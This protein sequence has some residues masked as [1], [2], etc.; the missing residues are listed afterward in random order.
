MLRAPFL[1]SLLAIGATLAAQ[2]PTK[3]PPWWNVQDDVTVS[4]SY[5]FSGPTP[6]Q[7]TTAVVPSWYS[8]TVTAFTVPPAVTLIPQLNGHTDVLGIVG[9]GAPRS[10]LLKL[11]VDN[12]PHLDWVKIFWFQFDSFEGASGSIRKAIEQDLGQYK[13]T[14]VSET[15]V[16]LGS[17]W[18]QVTIEAQLIPQPGDETVDWT[19]TETALGAVAIDN[20]FVSS[21]CVKPGPDETGDAMGQIEGFAIDLTN[22]T[23]ADCR[24][25]AVTFGPA[26][27][28]A[29][30]YWISTRAT[31]T[32]AFHQVIRLNQ[33][34]GPIST[35]PL[36]QSTVTAPSGA[37]DLAV[38]TVQ[39]APGVV[40]QFVYALVDSRT[41]ATNG[42][43]LYQIDASSGLLVGA[44]PLPSFPA[45]VAVPNQDLGLAFDPSGNTGQGTFWVTAT[46]QLGNGVAL[47][48]ARNG[49]L[50]DTKSNLP[51]QC[52]GLGYD[53]AL[54]NFYGFSSAVQASPSGPVQ[55]NGF[56]WSG[57]D[58]AL[59]GNRFCGDLTLANPGG[60]RGGVAR[61]FDVYRT[62]GS[63]TSELRLVCVV[64]AANR[65]YLYE[66]AGPFGFG[67]SQFGRCKMRGGVPF[68]GNNNFQVALTGVPDAL[69][70]MMYL[71]FSNTTYSGLPL[72]LPLTT[73]GMPEG[74]LSISLDISGPLA[75][76]SAPGE[77]SLGIAIPPTPL[78]GYAPVFFQ[79]ILLD[80]NVPGFLAASQAG[81]TVLYP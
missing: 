22:S 71:G 69:F 58:F 78:L 61:G 35:T 47:E 5:N 51:P 14:I 20:L 67:W 79:W 64:Q 7:P 81:K 66:L 39:I 80:P 17:G 43:V 38:E 62:R 74:S 76:P 12:D 23:G 18:N 3:P 36:P 50:L 28:F 11:K 4:L 16:P 15:S 10:G 42:V 77:F 8:P 13:R 6:F 60:P 45:L 40:Q 29:R 44:V 34:G 2:T 19:M 27:T 37:T 54:G 52:G 46:T 21:K 48:F 24:A 73:L 1:L 75:P 33:S 65:Q 41:A 31:L 68:L 53:D 56:E 70:G 72:P 25:A 9:S 49:V 59:T 55:V 30:S 32:G 57:Y 63:L 26:P